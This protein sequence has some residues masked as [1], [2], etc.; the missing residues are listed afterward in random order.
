MYLVE[1]K[2][3][4]ENCWLICSAN[5]L[6]LDAGAL[7][8]WCIGHVVLGR[9]L[10]SALFGQGARCDL[11]HASL[12]GWRTSLRHCGVVLGKRGAHRVIC[13]IWFEAQFGTSKGV[14]FRTDGMFW[15]M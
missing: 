1:V 6:Q 8:P 13:L 2:R 10:A 4:A 9:A 15:D 5:S 14:V 12:R 11:W 7:P 3:T